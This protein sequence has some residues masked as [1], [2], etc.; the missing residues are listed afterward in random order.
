MPTFG[1]Q[2]IQELTMGGLERAGGAQGFESAPQVGDISQLL[3]MLMGGG[4][5]LQGLMQQLQGLQG[6]PTATPEIQQY[7][8]QAA[9]APLQG[10]Q[11]ALQDALLQ[12]ANSANQRGLAG[13]SSIAAAMQAQAVPRIMG[14]AFA[15]AQGRMGELLLQLPL[16]QRQLALQGIQTGQ[17][18][19]GTG[20]QGAQAQQG[21]RESAFNQLQQALSRAASERD[22]QKQAKGQGGLLRKLLGG[23]L[24]AALS[25]IPGVGPIIG[26]VVGGAV[27][28]GGGGGVGGAAQGLMGLFGGGGAGGGANPLSQGQRFGNDF[29]GGG[30]A[31]SAGYS[32]YAPPQGFGMA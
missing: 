2:R 18:L 16:Q 26:P 25:F 11:P 23:A 32:P 6:M 4:Q 27:A 9:F 7:A 20:M 19:I 12:A 28:G 31:P 29:G 17:G 15:Q 8:Q 24:G 1:N 3:Q 21:L 13:G 5:G 30:Y 22:W 14:P 10:L